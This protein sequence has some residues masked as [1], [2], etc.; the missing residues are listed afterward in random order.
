LFAA[1]TLKTA[2]TKKARALRP[3]AGMPAYAPT[4]KERKIVEKAAGFGLP[5]DKIC[6]LI[7]SER[8]GK[9]IGLYNNAVHSNNPAGWGCDLSRPCAIHSCD[10]LTPN[11][12]LSAICEGDHTSRARPAVQSDAVAFISGAGSWPI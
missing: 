7:V 3:G 12:S 5:H 2:S 6:Q 11:L 8:T 4:A 9:P 1:L 10:A